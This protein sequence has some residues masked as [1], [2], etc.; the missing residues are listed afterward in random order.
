M[1]GLRIQPAAC[2]RGPTDRLHRGKVLTSSP[3]VNASS[4]VHSQPTVAAMPHRTMSAMLTKRKEKTIPFYEVETAAGDLDRTTKALI[5]AEITDI[6][7]RLTGA[8]AMFVNVMFREYSDG[9][10]FVGRR[11]QRRSFILGG[12]RHGRTLETRQELMRE[13]K[14]MWVRITGQSEVHLLVGLLEVDPA[15][16]LEAGLF[17]PEPGHEE[18]WFERHRATLEKLGVAAEDAQ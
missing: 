7:C 2:R 15:M 6:H 5:A 12:I 10:C 3:V 18:S 8:P 4:H 13:F 14:D 9:D 1:C 11:P 16:A 17:M